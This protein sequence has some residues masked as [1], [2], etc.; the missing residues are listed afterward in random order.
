MGKR[1]GVPHRD[2]EL[3]K[4]STPE[5]ETELER[6]RTRLRIAPSAKAAKGWRTRIH[7]I[8]SELANRD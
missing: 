3:A 6:S 5:V 2:E 8:E 1:S 4:L 7:W